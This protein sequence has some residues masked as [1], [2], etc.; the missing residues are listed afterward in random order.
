M[1]YYKELHF[2]DIE[3]ARTKQE[4]MVDKGY[5]VSL[6]YSKEETDIVLIIRY[7]G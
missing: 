3:K 5:H 4:E 6:K 1:F 2:T 7:N